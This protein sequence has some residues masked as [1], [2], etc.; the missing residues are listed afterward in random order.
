MTKGG[1][2]LY[3]LK[4][5][6]ILNEG[7]YLSTQLD[8]KEVTLFKDKKIGSIFIEDTKI[9]KNRNLRAVVREKVKDGYKVSLVRFVD[10]HR[11]TDGS[12]LD[13]ASRVKD[14]AEKT[15]YAGGLTN[16]GNMYGF[17]EYYKQMKNLGKQPILGFEAYCET[18]EGKKEGNH[19]IL[20]AKN[21]VGYKNLIKLTSLGF[22][23]FYRHP[24]I[25]YA[26]L[27]KHK[28]GII[29]TSACIGSEI[30]QKIKKGEYENAKDVA[31][32][33]KDMFGDDFYIEIQRHN[34][35]HEENIINK[36]LIKLSKETNIKLVAATDSHYTDKED[37]EI[38]QILLCLQ[39]GKTLA[40][41]D[42]MKFQ[43][44]GYHIHSADEMDEKFRDLPE[45]L[46]NTLEIGEKCSGFKLDLGNIYMPKFEVPEGYTEDSYLE[47]L[48]WDGFNERFKGKPELD[49]DEYVN[50]V[51]YELSVIK[52]MGYSSYFL[53]VSD[54]INYAKNNGIMV[55]PGRG[56]AVGSLVS[57]A[58]GIVDLDPIPYELLFER[59]LNPERVS[60][61]DIDI[62]FCYER[63]EEVIEYVKKKY[64]EH[65]V[66]KIITFGTLGA[67]AVVR[68]VA[69]VMNY[70]YSLGDKI[71]KAIPAVPGMTLSKAMKEN[72]ELKTM[73]ENE[74]D[75]R[76]VIDA[77]FRLEG[78]SRHASQH[79]CGVIIA[80]GDVDNYLPE[81]MMGKDGVK[82]RT[83]QVTMTEVE[84]LG[85]LKMDFLGLRTMTVIDYTI[86]SVAKNT[87]DNIK[88]LEI[89]N[90]D[91]YVY[92]DI[93]KGKSYA[94][95]QLE[96][97][98]MRS[99]MSELYSDVDRRIKQIEK[100]HKVKGF[101]NP[102]G[103]GDKELFLKDMA[104]LGK[105][106][107][108]RLIAGIALYRPGPMDY[109]P[110]YIEGMLNPKDIEYETPKLE[111]ILKATYGTIVYQEQVMRI[112]QELAGYSLGRADL[113]RRAMGKKND[114]IMKQEKNYFINGKL[115]K[116]NTI[117]VPGCVRNG[118][119]A[120]VA[121]SIWEK[122]E[123][124]SKYAFNKSHAAAYAVIGVKTAWLK[125]YYPVDFMA[126]TMNSFINKADRLKS[127]LSVCKDMNINILAPDANQ[128]FEL[129]SRSGNDV[130]FGLKGIKNMGATS[131]LILV[132]RN[133]RGEF[134]DYQDFA[135]R[136]AKYQR[137]DKRVLEG[138]IYAGA[139]DS[140]EGTRRGKLD[141]LDLILKAASSEK[142]DY[143]SGQMNLLD[144]IPD[145]EMFKKVNIPKVTEFDKRYKLE[146]E[147]E[148]A[149]FYVT[150][151]P[152]D[153]YD[154]YFKSEN[155]TEIG[156]LIA[157]ED[158]ENLDEDGITHSYDGE[159]VK[160]AGIIKDIKVFYSKKDNKPLYV[161]QVEGRSGE[162]KCVLFN[163]RIS[164]NQDKIVDGKIVLISGTIKEDD[165]GSQL[166][167]DSMVDIETL[168]K[169]NIKPK[170]IAI[171]AIESNQLNRLNLEILSVEAHKGEIPIYVTVNGKKFKSNNMVSINLATISKLDN[172]F[173]SNYRI[174]H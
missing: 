44:D 75:V 35:G 169:K 23:N 168:D 127:Y 160:V 63:R 9:F 6:E 135:V 111:P 163:N 74:S 93:A 115:N 154:K 105:E 120:H 45:A 32:K 137:I 34:I 83:S 145:G 101:K 98:G 33:L 87:S 67:R 4:T 22:E 165:W 25:N 56:S 58:I 141:V 129:F 91:P 174:V 119:P 60:M 125:Y 164:D 72:P 13:G 118:I 10:I 131:E 146:K 19:L 41:E 107:F 99:L 126:S 173:G 66:S 29:V 57:Y 73:Y 142:K 18:L 85:L 8:G 103:S 14:M 167:V 46:D 159:K 161:F 78:L 123:D 26:M 147:K 133:A 27:E 100:R 96:S 143:Q 65:A 82:E 5:N 1:F 47:K 172:I 132:E 117:D 124:F 150:E 24:H 130:I 155:I 20:L 68:D 48:A 84:E 90:N 40:D 42:R 114:K 49:S 134:L 28:E 158:D 149:G 76:T 30:A 140:F 122:M 70:N 92:S 52:Q 138:V 17:L 79:A 144:L 77:S 152:L 16:H 162:L 148:Y 69:R 53:I 112:V 151:H 21:E 7:E 80:D 108:E 12:L 39:T 64:G 31:L 166:I 109:I 37:S 121:E 171:D 102:K 61:P 97:P 81:T 94:V 43:G 128:S 110:N 89:P 153:D 136:M 11:H 86:K 59:F 54:F 106:L 104:N 88:Y 50:R 38:H 170:L 71:A 156:F 116:D 113:V 51:K 157:N 95:F 3:I 55:G 62:D 2:A 36:G 15:E 139:L